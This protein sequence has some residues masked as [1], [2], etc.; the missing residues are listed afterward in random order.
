MMDLAICIY[1]KFREPSNQ[2]IGLAWVVQILKPQKSIGKP[3]E[4][5]I[6]G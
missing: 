3:Q 4:G 6:E 5:N 2:A 1:S